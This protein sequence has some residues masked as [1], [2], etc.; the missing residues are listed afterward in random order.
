MKMEQYGAGSGLGAQ[1]RH[2]RLRGY[3]ILSF[4]LSFLS[5]LSVSYPSFVSGDEG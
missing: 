5:F 2:L 3:T 1:E 4:F